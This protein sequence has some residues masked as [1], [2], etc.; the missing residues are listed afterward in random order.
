[1]INR[2]KANRFIISIQHSQGYTAVK[3][4][5][6]ACGRFSRVQCNDTVFVVTASH[7]MSFPSLGENVKIRVVADGV[8][9]SN[10]YIE[11]ASKVWLNFIN[12]GANR[13]NVQALSDYINNEVWKLLN[14]TKD[15]EQGKIRIVPPTIKFRT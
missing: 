5:V 15:N 12:G 8:E 9:T 11:S 6:N 10:V 14:V 2:Y 13:K 3:Q 1:M 4:A 7:G